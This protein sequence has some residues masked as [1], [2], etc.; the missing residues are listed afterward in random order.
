[1]SEPRHPLRRASDYPQPQPPNPPPTPG[2]LERFMQSAEIAKFFYGVLKGIVV[3]VVVGVVG[4]TT[5][6]ADIK[7]AG[8]LL[9]RI[10]PEV[11]KLRREVD[12]VESDIVRLKADLGAIEAQAATARAN[13]E[14]RR[15][16]DEKAR[17]EGARI[18]AD[19]RANI[20]VLEE[21]VRGLLERAPP[22]QLT[23]PAGRGGK[24]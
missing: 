1:M 21:R 11:T 6:G 14:A 4:W 8:R 10:D 2:A 24:L 13:A 23:V 22:A 12:A 16:A 18:D 5:L 17:A 15:E 19:L 7:E 3:L 9:T 20:Q